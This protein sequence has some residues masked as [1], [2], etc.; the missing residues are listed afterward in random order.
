MRII[1]IKNK[2]KEDKPLL[3]LPSGQ[4][5]E[6]L[7]RM[8]QNM[9]KDLR[10]SMLADKSRES[11]AML[12]ARKETAPD[13]RIVLVC[14]DMYVA[15]EK[16]LREAS[17]AKVRPKK[18][19]VGKILASV[20][21][22]LQADTVIDVHTHPFSHN[23]VFSGV[24]DYDERRF[25]IWLQENLSGINY[26]S[27]LLSQNAWEARI[28]ENGRFIPACL[29]PQTM[30]ESV[31]HGRISS[32]EI[33]IP[34]MQARTA[35]AIGADVIRA[36][37]EKQ[38]IVLAGVGGIG[39][40]I[41]EQVV[42]SGFTQIGLIDPDILELSNLNRFS[43]GYISNLGN[44]K[45]EI[46][47]D[48]IK[49]VNPEANVDICQ[50]SLDSSE[51]QSM[52]AGADWIIVSTDSHSSR[53]LAQDTALQYGVPLISAGVSILVKGSDGSPQ[54]IDRS[55][56][57][58][59]A[60]YGDGFCLHCLRRI[61]PY[62]VAAETNPDKAVRDGLLSKGYVTGMA[63]KEPA[64]MPLNGVLASIAVQTLL[65]QYRP[66]SFSEPITIFESH[67]GNKCYPDTVSL[68][69][70]PDMC[71]ACGRNIFAPSKIY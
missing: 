49:A 62:K 13:G 17:L 61:N 46:V 5:P 25:S 40:A 60:R 10:K 34:E 9:L 44:A 43:G 65:D 48:L 41:A 1:K 7:I 50:A 31:P 26:A 32:A 53:A 15:A 3:A 21:N 42:R 29:K 63:E 4:K 30:A 35:L 2:R 19:F 64:V 6:P 70:L 12:T 14:Q 37:A 27:L 8:P 68:E 58:I 67:M 22:D 69:S 47:R 51:A 55:G 52:M 33:A 16:D 20:Q 11:F 24:D 71:P 39:S 23:A 66:T 54:L 57:V 36:I 56:E 28:W 59:I 38:K 18:D 45:V